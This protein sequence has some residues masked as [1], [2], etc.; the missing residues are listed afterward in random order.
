ML[1]YTFVISL[2]VAIVAMIAAYAL[3]F[4]LFNGKKMN[5]GVIFV[6]SAIYSIAW[7]VTIGSVIGLLIQKF[8]L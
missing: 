1:L 8:L 6:I 4:R 2:S 3:A 5:P 7:L